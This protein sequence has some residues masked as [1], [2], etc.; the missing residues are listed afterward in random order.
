M[1]PREFVVYREERLT[2]HAVLTDADKLAERLQSVFGVRK[3][4]RYATVPL[5]R[6]SGVLQWCMYRSTE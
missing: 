1:A 4:D 3:G 6:V 5:S 2:F